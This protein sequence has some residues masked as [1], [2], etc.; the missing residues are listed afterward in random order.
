MT[1]PDIDILS[2][3][4]TS[5]ANV[6][7]KFSDF[8]KEKYVE[9]IKK[10]DEE[11]VICAKAKDKNLLKKIEN[12]IDTKLTE[13]EIK[14]YNIENVLEKIINDS[15]IRSFFRKDPSKQTIH[16]NNQIFWLK[17]TKYPDA[18]KLPAGK[19][20]YYFC[21][22][23]LQNIH[24]RPAT[25][26]KTIDLHSEKSKIYG[27]LKYTT[28]DGGAQDN[29]YKDVKH[30]IEQINGY[31]EANLE[32]EYKFYFFLDGEYYEQN[33][34]KRINELNS[35]IKEDYKSRIIITKCQDIF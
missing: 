15:L 2:E 33:S 14:I 3:L 20:G 26:T 34:K 8:L 35:M 13:E 10:N 24:P 5:K 9:A 25:A 18:V 23:K 4:L 27:I 21:D 16:E 32:C 7:K 22:F 30:F 12:Y 6:S 31:C 19:G 1:E 28:C 11:I 17:Q 29:Q